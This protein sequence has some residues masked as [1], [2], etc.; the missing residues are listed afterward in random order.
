MLVKLS[1]PC[2]AGGSLVR[3]CSHTQFLSGKGTR[4]K[5][6]VAREERARDVERE[7]KAEGKARDQAKRRRQRSAKSRGVSPH[8]RRSAAAPRSRRRRGEKGCTAERSRD[9]PWVRLALRFAPM[10]DME[11]SLTC[12]RRTPTRYRLAAGKFRSELTW[13]DCRVPIPEARGQQRGSYCM[14]FY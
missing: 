10:P 11:A 9:M 5:S 3:C 12:L 2:R 14:S 13:L 8:S 1:S 7:N 4:I 6:A